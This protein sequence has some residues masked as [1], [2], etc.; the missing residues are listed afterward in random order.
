MNKIIALLVAFLLVLSV[1]RWCFGTETP[2]TLDFFEELGNEIDGRVTLN[3]LEEYLQTFTNRW[4][5]F[6]DPVY[7]WEYAGSLL[8][9]FGGGDAVWRALFEKTSNAWWAH[10]LALVVSPFSTIF[11]T[12]AQALL[13]LFT[14][15][16]DITAFSLVPAGMLIEYAI[17]LVRIMR[18][19]LFA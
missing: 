11:S 17:Y 2:L 5:A 15:I 7:R 4:G 16:S 8:A 14:Y 12:L 3:K 9:S 18:Y 1:A 13:F 19:L 6:D 10:T